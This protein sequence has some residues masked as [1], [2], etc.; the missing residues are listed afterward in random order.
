MNI[1]P[2]SISRTTKEKIPSKFLEGGWVLH[3]GMQ[4]EKIIK[5]VIHRNVQTASTKKK[6]IR[7]IHV[8]TDM[9]SVR[10]FRHVCN[11]KC[12]VEH[13]EHFNATHSCKKEI[14]KNV[15]HT[16]LEVVNKVQ[17]NLSASNIRDKVVS[18]I[19]E[20]VSNLTSTLNKKKVVV[21]MG[22]QNTE[23]CTSTGV[24]SSRKSTSM[25]PKRKTTIPKSSTV[26]PQNSSHPPPVPPSR[27]F[28]T[29]TVH[30]TP[31][32]MR[33]TAT[34]A[35]KNVYLALSNQAPVDVVKKNDVKPKTKYARKAVGELSSKAENVTTRLTTPK[36]T[37]KK[38][39]K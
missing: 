22:M 19:P 29:T 10:G 20:C 25:V 35:A 21:V 27:R 6:I 13:T 18:Y 39:K 37:C 38:G 14:V 7:H 11:R 24:P 9:P 4:T 17:E 28:S 16:D 34:S 31:L 1:A 23:P 36:A 32:T 26:S 5:R 15:V 33:Y 3:Q 2:G 12:L 8:Q 30:N